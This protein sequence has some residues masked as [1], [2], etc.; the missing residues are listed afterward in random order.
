MTTPFVYVADHR[1]KPH[2]HPVQTSSGRVLT[3]VEPDDHPWHRG[4][5]F[6][7]K[8]VGEENFWEEAPPYGV[9]R[10]RDAEHVDW[11]GGDRETVVI[12]E[13]R[14]QSVVRIDDAAVALD[15]S[16]ELTP[17]V[18]VVLDRTPFTTWGGYGGLTLRGRNDWVDTVLTLA[19]G[20]THE[21]VLGERSAWCDLTGTVDGAV[22]GLAIVDH[23][24]NPG[25][26][27]PWYGSTRADTY[28]DDGW[29]NFLNAA[30]LWDGPLAVAAGD[31]LALRYRVIAHDGPWRPALAVL[32]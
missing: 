19:D 7:I 28:G 12:T 2:W 23:P 32:S 30:F 21:R 25:H 3:R 6:T 31:T 1:R 5:W 9:L 22:A 13:R 18:D 11:I 15:V 17:A 26:P 29:S 14:Q 27:V 24:S 8:F 20:S 10:H 4:L 16:F